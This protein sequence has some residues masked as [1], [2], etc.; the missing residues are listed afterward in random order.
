MAVTSPVAPP[1]RRR[2]RGPIPNRIL[3]F[4]IPALAFY[5]FVVA[6]PTVQGAALAF[7]DWDGL[8]PAF[9]FVG[10]VN[11]VDVLKDPA[12]FRALLNTVVIAV[13][14]T[15]IQNVIGL[16]LA[17]GVNSKIKSGNV[18]KVLFFAPAVMTPVV[19]AYLWQFMLAP[20]G[21][22]NTALSGVGLESLTQVW[23]G[24]PSWALISIIVV[25]IWQFA[26][27]SMVIYLAGLQ[28]IPE[29]V[30]EASQVDGAGAWRRFRSIVLPLLA[31]AVT[32][33]LM[34]SMIGGLKVFDQV[35]VLTGGG[36]GGSTHTLT[37]LMFREAFT[38]GDYSGGVAMGLLLLVLVAAISA[39]QYRALL[40]REDNR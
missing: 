24:E 6:V 39:V 36:P 23:L 8:S 20:Q 25:L 30:I 1:P 28:G 19:V 16:G 13:A 9:E 34:L 21:P 15:L 11:I 17:L 33:N 10:L 18:L 37:T 14:F 31:P 26:G 7:T 29:E 4:A 5:A 12:S 3:W 2:P 35:W 38:F 40:K 22:V 32:I 27:Y